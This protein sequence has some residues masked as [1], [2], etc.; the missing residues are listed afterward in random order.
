M[1]KDRQ[2]ELERDFL[3]V[4]RLQNKFKS[5]KIVISAKCCHVE[6]LK[7][8]FWIN[9]MN[10]MTLQKLA[11]LMLARPALLKRMS[12]YAMWQTAWESSTVQLSMCELN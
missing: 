11:E 12:S 10:Q 3:V 8:A 7:Q 1:K 4:K 9:L 6:I 2:E 5:Y